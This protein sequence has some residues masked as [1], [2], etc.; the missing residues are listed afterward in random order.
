MEDLRFVASVVDDF[1]GQPWVRKKLSSIREKEIKGWEKW[2]Q[3]ELCM[4]LHEHEA[5]MQPNR[6]EKF[7]VDRRKSD[8]NLAFVDFVFRKKNCTK[9]LLLGVELKQVDSFT[10][11]VSKM[12]EDANKFYELKGNTL[13]D[14]YLL[15]VHEK[16]KPEEVVESVWDR[17]CSFLPSKKR[18]ISQPIGRTGYSY[19]IF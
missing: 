5:V 13:R 17:C 6:E 3:V 7:L 12:I 8:R 9:D 14:C 18:I 4:Y 10:T 1:F 11:C 16:V 2:V 19:T 15:G